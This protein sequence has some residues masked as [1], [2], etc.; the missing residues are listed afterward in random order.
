MSRNFPKYKSIVAKYFDQRLIH[1]SGIL[2]HPSAVRALLRFADP[3]RA[4]LL[5]VGHRTA[6][7]LRPRTAL[8]VPLALRRTRIQPHRRRRRLAI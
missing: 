2:L 6:L 1:L 5:E 8:Q 3:S 4:G 7:P